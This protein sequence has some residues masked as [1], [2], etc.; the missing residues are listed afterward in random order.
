ML[1]P[2][3]C[4]VATMEQWAQAAGSCEWDVGTGYLIPQ[5]KEGGPIEQAKGTEAMSPKMMM[6][7][8]QTHARPAGLGDRRYTMHSFRSGRGGRIAGDRRTRHRIHHGD[9][10]W[11]PER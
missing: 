4:V 6:T 10:G 7:R 5:I 2:D 1:M 3:T 9:V 11:N 8:L